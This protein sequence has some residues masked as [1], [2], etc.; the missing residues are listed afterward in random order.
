VP[1][2]QELKDNNHDRQSWASI[3]EFDGLVQVWDVSGSGTMLG[4]A[5]FNWNGHRRGSLPHLSRS[6][7]RHHLGPAAPQ[8][9]CATV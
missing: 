5:A 3:C 1:S 4:S 6:S 2:L 7:V 8:E 9:A